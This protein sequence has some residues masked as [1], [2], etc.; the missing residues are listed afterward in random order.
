M[1]PSPLLRRPLLFKLSSQ[2]ALNAVNVIERARHVHETAEALPE[3][4]RAASEYTCSSDPEDRSTL[5]VLS[6]RAGWVL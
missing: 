1:P 5:E 2:L 3:L 4:D 6:E